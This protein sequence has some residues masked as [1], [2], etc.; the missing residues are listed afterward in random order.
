MQMWSRRSFSNISLK[1]RRDAFSETEQYSSSLYREKQRVG[2]FPSSD[3]L[4]QSTL[5]IYSLAFVCAYDNNP[6]LAVRRSAIT[7][8]IVRLESDVLMDCRTCCDETQEGLDG[9]RVLAGYNICS[10][11]HI[12]SLREIWQLH[13]R[14]QQHKYV[15]I[16]IILW[17]NC[18]QFQSKHNNIMATYCVACRTKNGREIIRSAR[19]KMFPH[20]PCTTAEPWKKITPAFI[21]RNLSW[22]E[23]P[24]VF[25]VGSHCGR[26]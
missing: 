21:L 22:D 16:Y 14:K 20:R 5:N 24:Q 4:A 6:A 17:Q 25:R 15:E 9:V 7:V 2:A 10:L 12:I 11:Y 13:W 8:C 1:S 18:F 26:I 3:K 23:K 19:L